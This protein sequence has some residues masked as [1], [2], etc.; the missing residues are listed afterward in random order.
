MDSDTVYIMPIYPAGEPPLEGVS[1]R[2]I[3]EAV[4]QSGHKNVKIVNSHEECLNEIKKEIKEGDL[5][6]T[7]GAG[8][9]Y[10]IGE[11]ILNED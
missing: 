8:N 7:L 2:L 6:L 11:K 9:V 3:Y 4:K 5:L 10:K 1:H